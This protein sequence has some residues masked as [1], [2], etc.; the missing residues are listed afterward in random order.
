MTVRYQRCRDV[1]ERRVGV[2][3]VL[4]PV[5]RSA[6]MG[7]SVVSLNEVAGQ[8]WDAL[9]QPQSVDALVADVVGAFEVSRE[10]AR[11]DVQ[12]LLGELVEAELVQVDSG[13]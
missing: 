3:R 11:E 12:R 8:V 10:T 1:A 13:D 4:V 5:A 7:V 6:Q 2:E 9:A